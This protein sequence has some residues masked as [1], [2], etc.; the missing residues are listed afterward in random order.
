MGC[1]HLSPP[2]NTINRRGVGEYR[3]GGDEE[4][5]VS[6]Q[7]GDDLH[8]EVYISPSLLISIETSKHLQRTFDPLS[9]RR[10][11]LPFRMNTFSSFLYS[12]DSSIFV[13]GIMT[14]AWPSSPVTL[15]SRISF[16]LMSR[17][18]FF[19]AELGPPTF[20]TNGAEG[21]DDPA[22]RLFD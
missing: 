19:Y 6:W 1:G 21:N 12:Q 7:F 11:L 2:N 9:M 15:S 20:E 13:F 18:S 22:P 10:S 14:S 16:I 17:I 5:E 8:L 3:S 4:E